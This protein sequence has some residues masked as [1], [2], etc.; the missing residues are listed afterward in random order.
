MH[1]REF[2]EARV[3]FPDTKPRG[4]ILIT[5]RFMACSRISNLYT[6]IETRARI[7]D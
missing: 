6:H 2:E 1:P 4:G 7:R 5:S 3:A